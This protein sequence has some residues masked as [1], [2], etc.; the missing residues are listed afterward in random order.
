MMKKKN[1]IPDDLPQPDP[2]ETT[3]SDI[4]APGEQN[5][6]KADAWKEGHN[7]RVVAKAKSL[8]KQTKS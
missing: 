1:N 5:Q 3:I 8:T 4:Y 7:A 6:L 2:D